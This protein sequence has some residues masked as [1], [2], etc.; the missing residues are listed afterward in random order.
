[1]HT[2][3]NIC[4]ETLLTLIPANWLAIVTAVVALCSAV[5]AVTPTPK[6]GSIWAKLYAVVDLLALNFGFA[7]DKGK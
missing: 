3:I 7:K 1:M 5:A 4:M 6:P 2:R